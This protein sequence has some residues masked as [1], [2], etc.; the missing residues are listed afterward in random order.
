MPVA[1]ADG[2]ALPVTLR[3]PVAVRVVDP[4]A[5]CD[6]PLV[7]V[8]LITAESEE[9]EDLVKTEDKDAEGAPVEEEVLEAVEVAD[10]AVD[11]V[12]EELAERALVEDSDDS[13]E[14]V[15]TALVLRLRDT[16]LLLVLEPEDKAAEEAVAEVVSSLEADCDGVYVPPLENVGKLEPLALAVDRLV[17]LLEPDREAVRLIVGEAEGEPEEEPELVKLCLLLEVGAFPE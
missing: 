10:K 8:L 16:E 1:D 3:E 17:V 11:V 14:P 7:F 6:L 2:D 15:A 12:S 13:E 4:A 9:L 5:D